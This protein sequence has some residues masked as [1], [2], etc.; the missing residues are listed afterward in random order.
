MQIRLAASRGVKDFL[1]LISSLGRNWHI[2]I[3]LQLRVDW[4]AGA[5]SATANL[6]S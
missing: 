2:E 6:K 5:R 3:S 1:P 4:S